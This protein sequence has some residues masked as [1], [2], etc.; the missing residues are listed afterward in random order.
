MVINSVVNPTKADVHMPYI[1]LHRKYVRIL[2]R[3]LSRL[4]QRRET[5]VVYCK[6]LTKS[7]N[8]M[9]DKLQSSLRLQQVVHI[10]TA[11]L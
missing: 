7:I 6:A 8:T 3:H 4:I 2:I 9:R 11:E 10:A 5:S 1:D